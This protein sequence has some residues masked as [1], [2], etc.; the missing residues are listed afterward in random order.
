MR[1]FRNYEGKSAL[2]L[3]PV[4]ER[5]LDLPQADTMVIRDVINTQKTM[6]QRVKRI[7]VGK[8]VFLVFAATSEEIK[9][10]RLVEGIIRKELDI[11]PGFRSADVDCEPTNVGVSLARW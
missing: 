7:R 1:E 8:V 6:Y 4:G 11:K 9:V 5:D 3:S 10:D 2:V